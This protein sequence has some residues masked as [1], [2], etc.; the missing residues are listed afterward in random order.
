LLLL[1]A[2]YCRQGCT[3]FA[4]VNSMALEWV[5]VWLA[6]TN[7]SEHSRTVMATVDAVD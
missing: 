5:W 2:W 4:V 3:C 1:I 7:T 6:E